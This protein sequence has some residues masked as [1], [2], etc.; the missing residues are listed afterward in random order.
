MVDACS[1]VIAFT[2]DSSQARFQSDAQ[3]I[4]AVCFQI[5]ILGEGVKRL[6]SATQQ[7][8]P[9]IAWKQIAGMRDRLIHGYDD[10]D[11]EELWNTAVRDVP[12]LLHQLGAIE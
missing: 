8:Y 11:I 1:K 7:R 6:S 10:I 3:A 2:A 4:S 12:R 5:A 9:D